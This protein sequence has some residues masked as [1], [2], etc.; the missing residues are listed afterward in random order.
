MAVLRF[1]EDHTFTTIDQNPEKA[2]SV[3][4][5][6]LENIKNKPVSREIDGNPYKKWLC[7][8]SQE[9]IGPR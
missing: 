1:T 9:A 7:L 6:T 8:G 4:A 2:A 5:Q 3:V